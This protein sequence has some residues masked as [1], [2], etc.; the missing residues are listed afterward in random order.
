MS[1]R[2]GITE[3]L[4]QKSQRRRRA[5]TRAAE[6]DLPVRLRNDLLPKLELS[7]RDLVR[8]LPPIR[9]VRPPDA[10]HVRAV[11][12]A[13][14]SLGFT[15]PILIDQDDRVLDGWVRVEAA[16]QIGLSRVPCIVAGHL[17]T[18]ERRLLRI[19]VNRLGELGQ[20]E[21]DQLKLEFEE[22]VLED[23]DLD[24]SGFTDLEIDQVVLGEDADE[25]EEVA[26][27]PDGALEPM[28]RPGDVFCLGE[29]RVACGDA[30]DPELV[31]R[32]MAG[33]EARLVLTD[34][35][36]NVPIRGHVTGGDHREFAMASGEMSSEE[37]QAFNLAW[38]AAATGVLIDGGVIGTFIDWR[39]YP[40]VHA[41]AAT[42]GLAPLN[43]V[44]WTKSNAGMGSLYRSAHELLPLF[45]TGKADHVNNV[46]LGRHGR[47]RSNVWT[48]PGASSFGS[49][50]RKG[51]ESH[52]TVKPTAMLEDA[53]L[54]LT[55]RGEIVLD[56]FLG[57]GSTLMAAERSGRVCR[58]IEIDPLYVDVIIRR[59]EA[60]TG[61]KA[62]L[63]ATSDPSSH[64]VAGAKPHN[65][66]S[67]LS[68]A[69]DRKAKRSQKGTRGRKTS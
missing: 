18:A 48:Y 40:V 62:A 44:V 56:P 68:P 57:S 25:P 7:E 35:P 31:A 8:L 23:V 10:A 2:S 47:W 26:L 41:A 66:G 37:F 32:L 17:T 65:P 42:V 30:R 55:S 36:F 24:V 50:A 33:A 29:H 20:W 5:L 9:N 51:L 67:H 59:F 11:A 34:V 19:A 21:F 15:D 13:I 69:P 43:L 49:D 39:G 12:N 14:S 61:Q 16:R 27:A 3:A 46:E 6:Q 38:I 53:L 63:L 22:L 45:K 60:A 4:R 64:P 58:G 1:A 28:A 54:D 52:P